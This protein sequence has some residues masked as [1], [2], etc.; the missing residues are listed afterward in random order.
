MRFAFFA[1]LFVPVVPLNKFLWIV[2]LFLIVDAGTESRWTV[3]WPTSCS[4]AV[5]ISF[6][7]F[8]SP[9]RQLRD[10]LCFILPLFYLSIY[11]FSLLIHTH[12]SCPL[13]GRLSS[14]YTFF[15]FLRK[16]MCQ[17]PLPSFLWNWTSSKASRVISFV[18]NELLI[19]FAER[20]SGMPLHILQEGVSRAF[21]GIE[22]IIVGWATFGIF[23]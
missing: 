4:W 2:W 6:Y 18:W 11:Y 15:P 19:V 17:L 10:Y 5:S 21:E 22:A 13:Q 12:A 20:S 23:S 1:D 3:V 7:H 8:L 9:G 14:L 16:P